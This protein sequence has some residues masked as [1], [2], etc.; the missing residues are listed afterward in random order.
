[1]LPLEI[2][3]SEEQLHDLSHVVN[4]DLPTLCSVMRS[5]K[6]VDRYVVLGANGNAFDMNVSKARIIEEKLRHLVPD[7]KTAISL[8]NALQMRSAA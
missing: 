4:V 1:M 5:A 7:A 8:V 2:I 6:Y 3:P